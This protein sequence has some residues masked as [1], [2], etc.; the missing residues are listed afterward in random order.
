M[1]APYKPRKPG[2]LKEACAELVARCGGQTQVAKIWKCSAQNVARMT[3]DGNAQNPPRI[4]QIVVL[5]ALCREPIVTRYMAAAQNCIVEPV[6]VAAHESLPIV[7]G[8]ITSET[9]QLLSAAARDIQAG[10]LTATNAAA[11]L[12]ETDDVIGAIA[13]LRAEARAILQEEK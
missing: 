5:E 7:V 12:R 9:G 8:R 11:V 6:R 13:Q 3:D 2:S 1:T 4:D 10:R